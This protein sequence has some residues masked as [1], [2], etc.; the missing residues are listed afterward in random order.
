VAGSKRLAALEAWRLQ[1]GRGPEKAKLL[2]ALRQEP[3]RSAAALA[4]LHE[5]ALF[6]LAYPDDAEVHDQAAHL[7]A[8]L[9]ARPELLKFAEVLADSGIAGTPIHYRFYWPLAHWI[10]ERWPDRLTIDWDGDFE[11]DALLRWLPRI[12]APSERGRPIDED[13]LQAELQRLAAPGT[14]ASLWLHGLSGLDASERVIEAIH[15]DFD[16]PYRLAP[17][18]R[19]S[20]TFGRA[21]VGATVYQTGPFASG[22]PDLVA[23]CQRLP[24]VAE[25]PQAQATVLIDL[26]KEAMVTRSRDLE[27]FGYP[28]DEDVLWI[29]DGNGLAFA[30]IGFRR[31]RRLQFLA[32]YGLLT[33]KNGVPIGYVQLDGLGDNVEVSFNT[34]ETF[35]GAESAQ[36]FA[37]TLAAC[38]AIFGNASFSI[39]PY[40][41]GQHNDEAIESGAWWFYAKLGFEPIAEEVRAIVAK[42]RAAMKKKPKHRSSPKT[43]RALA[44]AHLHWSIDRDVKPTRWDFERLAIRASEWLSAHGAN[45]HEAEAKAMLALEDLTAQHGLTP[46]E[47]LEWRR[48]APV[49]LSLPD[50][51]SWPQKARIECGAV[52]RLKAAQNQRA[53]LRAFGAQSRLTAAFAALLDR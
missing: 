1:F 34:F 37:R 47:T 49:L 12:L 30:A 10:V 13:E 26:A 32:S 31:D 21:Q 36:I 44:E 38:R 28:N 29:D 2:E 8:E 6:M 17:G 40:Q 42:E 7:L 5:L 41:L 18:D 43:L 35:R 50:F 3:M 46:E 22:R 27:V 4:R 39:E 14:D 20:R 45:R 19:P 15:D 51:E 24:S 9:P 52:V 23:E 11:P 48:W 25:V 16:H 53:Y 33:L